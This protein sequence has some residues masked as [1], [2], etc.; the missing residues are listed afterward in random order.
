MSASSKN[1]IPTPAD[2]L[3]ARETSRRLAKFRPA[4]RKKPL[5]VRVL[6]DDG[7]EETVAIPAEVVRQLVLL[8]DETAAGNAVQLV[9]VRAEVTTQQAADLLC[10]S[11]P[12]L[13]GLLDQGAIPYRRVGTHRRMLFRDVLAYRH[14]FLRKRLKALEELTQLSQ[15]LGMG[16]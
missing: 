15:D 2:A 13:I 10:V 9:P 12:Y 6:G 1:S 5:R 14:D 7:T 16:Y 8:L 3:L 11:R 4:R